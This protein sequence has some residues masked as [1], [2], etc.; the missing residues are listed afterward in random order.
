MSGTNNELQPQTGLWR[1]MDVARFLALVDQKELY[2]SRLHEFEDKWEGACSPLDPLITRRDP[3]YMKVAATNFTALPLF[4]CWHESETESVAM[5]KLYLSGKEGVAIKTTA[6]SLIQLFSAGRELKLGRV[7]YRDVDDL[8]GSSE[9]FVFEDGLHTGRGCLPIES[10]LFRKNPGYAHEQEVRAV[11]YETFCAEQAIF[12]SADTLQSLWLGIRPVL[13]SGQ[14]LPFDVS[15]LIHRIVVS[16]EF[17]NWAV[18]SLQK[19][20]DAAFAPSPTVTIETSALLDIP[21]VGN[22]AQMAPTRG[23]AT[24]D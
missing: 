8:Q 6:A 19:A 15:I 2:F 13:P 4:S 20:V 18:K 10:N 22:L 7:G 3:D 11:I 14:S 1:Y 23:L 9:V 24:V 21:V 12:N 16:P 17:P 5:W